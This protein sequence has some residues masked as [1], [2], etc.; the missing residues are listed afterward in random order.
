MESPGQW[1]SLSFEELSMFLRT[2]RLRFRGTCVSMNFMTGQRVTAPARGAGMN[3]LMPV[4]AF[5]IKACVEI[6]S[7]A[8]LG[9]AHGGFSTAFAALFRDCHP[10]HTRL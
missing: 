6:K 3:G 8:G 7:G 5:E 4:T 2:S 9:I 10:N 1:K